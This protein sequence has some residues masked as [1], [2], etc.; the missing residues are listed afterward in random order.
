MCNINGNRLNPQTQTPFTIIDK[1][2]GNHA[3]RRP[4]VNFM[5]SNNIGAIPQDF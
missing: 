2:H 4:F 3:N 1:L 5:E